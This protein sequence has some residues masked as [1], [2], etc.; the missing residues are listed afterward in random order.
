MENLSTREYIDAVLSVGKELAD[1]YYKLD[2]ADLAEVIL[3]GLPDKYQPIF[4]GHWGTCGGKLTTAL[5]EAR[6]LPL[7]HKRTESRDDAVA[8]KSFIPRCHNSHQDGHIR[9]RC[10]Q[11]KKDKRYPKKGQSSGQGQSSSQGRFGVQGQSSGS[12]QL[13]GQTH[14][15]NKPARSNFVLAAALGTG[16]FDKNDWIVG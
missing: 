12:G 9:P 10:P 13:S 5:V 8:L 1:I 15:S 4:L 7:D 14:T 11:M 2:D 3:N 6:L 16:V